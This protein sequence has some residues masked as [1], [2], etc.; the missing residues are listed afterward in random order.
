MSLSPPTEKV[1]WSSDG[2]RKGV[3]EENGDVRNWERLWVSVMVVGG[4]AMGTQ[5][6][7]VRPLLI[8][9]WVY[10]IISRPEALDSEAPIETFL[11]GLAIINFAACF[12]VPVHIGRQIMKSN[13]K[14]FT[15]DFRYEKPQ[16]DM[17]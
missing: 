3:L 9:S 14:V 5:F 12:L 17:L 11:S 8:T 7:T 6:E 2:L 10:A 15:N 16:N 13:Y 1:L 4:Q